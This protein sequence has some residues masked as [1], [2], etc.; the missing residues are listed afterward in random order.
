MYIPYMHAHCK[1]KDMAVYTLYPILGTGFQE[2]TMEVSVTS[3]VKRGAFFIGEATRQRTEISQ[4]KWNSPC[5]TTRVF[6]LKLTGAKGHCDSLTEHVALLRMQCGC[7]WRVWLKIQKCVLCEAAWKAQLFRVWAFYSQEHSVTIDLSS[8]SWPDN[9]STV[10]S[11]IRHVEVSG[12]IW[13][14]SEK[15]ERKEHM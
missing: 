2:I 4:Y 6:K 9:N 7:V 3:V 14:Y 5:I 8:G 13:L 10:F 1:V 12:G 15:Q 11:H